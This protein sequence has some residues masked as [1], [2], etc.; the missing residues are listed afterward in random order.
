MWQQLKAF[1]FQKEVQNLRIEVYELENAGRLGAAAL[2]YE[3]E[4]NR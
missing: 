4:N 2:Q 3:F 1:G